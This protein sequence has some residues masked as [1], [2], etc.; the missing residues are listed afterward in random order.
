MLESLKMVAQSGRYIGCIVVL[1]VGLAACSGKDTLPPAQIGET[2]P[3][4]DAPLYRIG[5]GDSLQLFV[6]RNPELSTT[7]SVRPD[8]RISVP[9]I[10]DLEAAG[11]TPTELADAVEQELGVFIQ[12]PFVTVIMSSFVGQFDQQ[13]RVLGEA[14]NPQSIPYRADMT[15]LDVMIS[16]GGL[17][18][19]ADGDSAT[20]V[21]VVEG[22][23]TEYGLRL[24]R[25]MRDGDVNANVALLPGDVIIIPESFL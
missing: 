22:Q 1:A 11:K 4:I 23:Q 14:A 10:E 9:L 5:P 25:L 24:G 3:G 21:R 7:V 20:L 16:V 19:F 12:D 6:W 13:V 8:G 15:L 17:T 18:E 2:G